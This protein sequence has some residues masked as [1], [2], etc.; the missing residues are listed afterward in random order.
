MITIISGTNRIGSNTK[1]VAIQYH[2]ML[3]A[4]G[5]DNKML[6]LE[7][8]ISTKRDEHFT[9]IEAE[10]LIPAEKFIII[11]PEYN[12][13]FPGVLKLLFD[14]S[15]IKTTWYNKKICLTGVASGRAGNNRGMDNLTNIFN[16]LH[17]NI[18]WQK[19]PLSQI[20]TEL[21]AEGELVNEATTQLIQQQLQ[22]FIAF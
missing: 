4:M 21:N 10:Y 18:Y 13:S 17:A 19:I 7:W 22:G 8:L 20:N 5:V 11:S 1:K 15:D 2:L 14:I 3:N 16:Y 9:Q 6:D 12:G